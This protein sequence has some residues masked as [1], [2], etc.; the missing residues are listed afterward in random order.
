MTL[1]QQLDV[2]M[3]RMRGSAERDPTHAR[4]MRG[5]KRGT[6]LSVARIPWMRAPLGTRA[7]WPAPTKFGT[8]IVWVDRKHGSA[9]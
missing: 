6:V 8:S 7:V 2:A 9:A 4:H 1:W 5:L 3:A